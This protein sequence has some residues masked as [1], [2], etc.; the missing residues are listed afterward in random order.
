MRFFS[1]HPLSTRALVPILFSLLAFSCIFFR[2]YQF[3]YGIP[4]LHSFQGRK[5]ASFHPDEWGIK[6]MT[7]QIYY[8]RNPFD[9][10]GFYKYGAVNPLLATSLLF[11]RKIGLGL[12]N[13]TF[14]F[15][16]VLRFISLLSSILTV[17]VVFAIGRR[18]SY[19][20]AFLSSAFCS[21]CMILARDARWA[22]PDPL[23]ALMIAGAVLYALKALERPVLSNFIICALFVAT[24]IGSKI[25]CLAF[26]HLPLLAFVLAKDYKIPSGGLF[27][28]FLIFKDRRVVLPLLVMGILIFFNTVVYILKDIPGFM[29]SVYLNYKWTQWGSMGILPRY[30]RAPHY[31]SDLIPEA[32]GWPL[33]LLSLAGIIYQTVIRRDKKAILI[34]GSILFFWIFLEINR[35]TT[36]RYS[37]LI[38]TFLVVFAGI[39]PAQLLER[40]R[41]KNLRRLIWGVTGAVFIY[42]LLYTWTFI[43]MI[44]QEKGSRL[45]S[46]NWIVNNIPIRSKLGI[47][48]WNSCGW[49]FCPSNALKGY[50]Y[51]SFLDSP[52]Y[53][54]L[55][56]L[57][58]V[59]M[60]TYF[61]SEKINY[62]YEME[63]WWP[64]HIPSSELINL[65]RD[66]LAE[67]GYRL[68]KT[69]GSQ[70]SVLGMPI[71]FFGWETE[72][73]N[74][75]IRIYQRINP[76]DSGRKKE[77]Q[78]PGWRRITPETALIPAGGFTMGGF[79]D[80]QAH[81]VYLDAYEIG[82]YE[83]TNFQYRRFL[84]D[85]ANK[86]PD[87][88]GDDRFS[89]DDQPVV[90]VSWEDAFGFCSWLSKITSL[91]YRLP[92]EAEW[93]KAARGT[94]G[95]KYPWGNQYP[96]IT[97]AQFGLSTFNRK[98][99]TEVF[100]IPTGV[101]PYGLFHMSGNAYEWV[102]D[103]FD[104]DYY[105]RS[106]YKNPKGPE[107]GKYKVLRGGSW[108][109][110]ENFLKSTNRA[111]CFPDKRYGF[112]GYGFRVVRIIKLGHL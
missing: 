42:S 61:A 69:F 65:Y 88:W 102:A 32:M 100:R 86:K 103:W 4:D 56:A 57:P 97:L 60:E 45:S 40:T 62:S 20:A 3:N 90:G 16:R 63:D 23:C 89:G 15:Y 108:V 71:E 26:L 112:D 25:Y 53:F 83:I 1:E 109:Y 6:Y 30:K 76:E 54:I 51:G 94:D 22:G 74:P 49:S 111:I 85:T 2:A 64:T 46:T 34:S 68:L 21:V 28:K 24:S 39:F 95:R 101:S 77:K 73:I 14:D 50:E 27:E 79:F 96:D 58:R 13:E 44:D 107:K 9:I 12:P 66:I 59:A 106:T 36:H 35:I 19:A 80:G 110:P 72:V 17:G 84:K 37:L 5:I 48:K 75:E 98:P 52:D 82:K 92:T 78:L 104:K 81:Q 70:P 18:W 91:T 10:G 99:T 41:K 67:K 33:Y 11:I 93:E 87:Y 55:P 29:D 8:S 47:P 7:E 38:S 31:F 105:S 43:G